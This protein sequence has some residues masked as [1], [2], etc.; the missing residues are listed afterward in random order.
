[1]SNESSHDQN[2]QRRDF[3]KALA[4]VPVFGFFS[5]KSLAETQKRCIE[6]KKSLVDLVQGKATNN[7]QKSIEWKAL[8]YWYY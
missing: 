5:S 8:K 6:K 2:V 4:T 1:M 7:N 3:I